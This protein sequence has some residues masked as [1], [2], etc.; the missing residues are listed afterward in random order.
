MLRNKYLL[1]AFALISLTTKAQHPFRYDN[2]VYKTVYL[3]DAFRLMDTMQNFLLL[4]VRTPGEY[5]DTS[6]ATA[7]NIGR[8]KGAVNINIDSIPDHL[9]ELRKFM[10]QPIF[11]YCSHSQ[12]SRRVSKL[13]ADSGFLKV[14]NINGGM[15]VVNESD[16]D[17]FIYKNKMLVTHTSYKNIASIDAFN[18]NQNTPD[19]VIIDIRTEQEFAGKDTLQQNNIGHLKNAI[20]I[21]QAV[22]EEKIDSYHLANT[23][24]VL[25]YDLKGY[26][27]MDVVEILRARGFTRI[28]NLFE[29]L[30]AFICDHELIKNAVNPLIANAPAWRMLDAKACIDLLLQEKNLTILDARPTDEFENKSTVPYKNLGRM[31]GSISVPS[32]EALE[33]TIRQTDKSTPVLI[34]GSNMLGTLVCQ[35]LT[36]KGF[37]QVYFLSQGYYHF[38]W[39]TAN[40]EN[41]KAGSVFLVNHDG[42]Y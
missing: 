21:P 19:L 36:K 24:P 23:R 29:G 34:Y 38:V 31:N 42:L 5:A 9:T 6:R 26:N 37:L 33:I 3:N 17:Q 27:S 41:C 20:N 28:Y 12:R 14:Y 8:F 18:L 16:N 11:I 40:I 32:M 15:T 30:E 7:L 39:S 35:E 22:F 1:L 2:T 25:L 13:L 10:D 4:D